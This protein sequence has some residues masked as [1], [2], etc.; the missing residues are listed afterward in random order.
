M[1][2]INEIFYSL[3][4]EGMNTGTAAIFIR[5]SG[6]NLNCDFCDTHHEDGTMM[7]DD[8]IICE[9]NKYPAKMVVLT[10]G[11]P[12]LWIDKELIEKLHE[13]NKFVTIETNGTNNLPDGID[14]VTC[15]PKK[16]GTVVLNHIDELKVVYEGQ[17]LK[18]YDKYITCNRFLQPCSNKNV[19]ETIEC[20]KKYPEWRLSLQTHIIVGIR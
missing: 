18:K 14:W 4:G 15:S 2:K 5:F 6:C 17:S 13:I 11:E 7:T 16:G 3:Q 12:S 9:V 8:D 10:G 19:K 1:K 20:I